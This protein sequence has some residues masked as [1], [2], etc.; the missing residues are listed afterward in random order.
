MKQSI[1]PD[2]ILQL[3]FE[4]IKDTA[5]QTIEDR[6]RILNFY[7]GIATTAGTIAIGISSIIGEITV[8]VVLGVSLIT[9]LLAFSGW[10]FLAMMIRLRQAWFES[11]KAMNK[12]K[13]YYVKNLEIEPTLKKAFLWNQ[14]TL[15]KPERFWNIH[16]F[17]SLLVNFIS[18]LSLGIS[19]GFIFSPLMNAQS[20]IL[21]GALVF[22]ASILILTIVYWYS[23]KKNL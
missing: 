6:N 4:Y 22:I 17:A 19:F 21:L 7:L 15:P 11:M 1:S 23:L 2:S 12:I 9:F 20:V 10:I 13:D 16:F 3:E 8:L 14:S 5:N 18:S